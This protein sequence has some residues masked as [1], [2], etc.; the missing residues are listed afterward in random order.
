M[1]TGYH[2]S[3]A[4]NKLNHFL[5]QY[6]NIINVYLVTETTNMKLHSLWS[7][8]FNVH[9]LGL[10]SKGTYF[11][12]RYIKGGQITLRIFNGKISLI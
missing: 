1:Q 3:T 10:I 11:W 12:L 2:M 4:L 7:S 5:G 9:K 8:P 6:V